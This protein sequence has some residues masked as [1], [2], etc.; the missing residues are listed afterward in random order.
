M[1]LTAAREKAAD[2]LRD[3]ADMEYGEPTWDY[4]KA[5]AALTALINEVVEEAAKCRIP[6]T[7]GRDSTIQDLRNAINALKIGEQE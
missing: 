3:C 4:K 7:Y 2:V 5:S 6:R 1:P